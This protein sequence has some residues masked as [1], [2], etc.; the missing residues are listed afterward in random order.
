MMSSFVFN[1]KSSRDF[2]L[3]VDQLPA[4]VHPARRGDP[5][6][7]AGC[8]GTEY[9]ED[10]TYENYTQ[11]FKIWFRDF[12]SNRDVYQISNDIA[13]WL[14]CSRNF[15]RFEDTYEPEYFRMARFAGPLNIEA[16]LRKYG[17]TTL[18]FEF[19]PERYLKSG[20]QQVKGSNS[21]EL[22]NP[23]GQIARPRI[24]MQGV[25]K[26]TLVCNAVYEGTMEHHLAIDVDFGSSGSTITIDS[27][28]YKATFANGS[29]AYGAL[30]RSGSKYPSLPQL[31]RGVNHIGQ[32]DDVTTEGRISSIEIVPR[33][34]TV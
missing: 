21:I 33:W 24:K 9:Q 16:V 8:N 17:R 23:T 28:T 13:T 3:N 14:L 4:P 26:T 2:C 27:N 22:S 29:D 32:V 5:Y 20:E 19:K 34:W 12:V 25:G 18:E 31:Y 30:S 11:P 10:G 6:R 15:C 7:I 1:G